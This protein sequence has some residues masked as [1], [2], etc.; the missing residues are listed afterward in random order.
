MTPAGTTKHLDVSYCGLDI[1]PAPIVLRLCHLE[2]LHCA[3]K[4]EPTLVQMQLPPLEICMG[5]IKSIR[6]FFFNADQQQLQ[7]IAE[8][9]RKLLDTSHVT[10]AP[11]IIAIIRASWSIE[12]APP[13]TQQLWVSVTSHMHS[14]SFVPLIDAFLDEHIDRVADV[15]NWSDYFGRS[16]LATTSPLCKRAML[17]RALFVGKYDITD[18]LRHEYKS[19]TCTVYLVDLVDDDKRIRVA[20][21]FMKNAHEFEREMRSRDKLLALAPGEE[22]A[23]RHHVIQVLDSYYH[24]NA[25]FQASM[26]KRSWLVD[27]DQPCLIV[28]PAADRNLRVIMDNERIT[29]TF[30]IKH[31]FRQIL[32]CV[33]CMHKRSII[34]GDL[35]PRNIVRTGDNLSLIDLDCS[36]EIGEMVAGSKHSSAY[37]PPESLELYMSIPS[38]DVALFSVSGADQCTVSFVLTLPMDVAPNAE[39][40]IVIPS[41][42]FSSVHSL[43][44]D[45]HAD[46]SCCTRVTGNTLAIASPV[47]LSVGKH[48]FTVVVASAGHSAADIIRPYF[49]QELRSLSVSLSN[50]QDTLSKCFA[51]ILRV[52]I[53]DISHD[54]WSL[55]VIL[56]RFFARESL[57]YEDDEDNIKDGSEHLL[58]LALWTDAFKQERLQRID[59][60]ATRALLSKLLEKEPWNRPRCIEDVIKM[61]FS[62]SDIIESKLKEHACIAHHDA[63]NSSN[64]VGDVKDLRTAKLS[65]AAFGLRH[66]LKVADNWNEE[67]ACT[68]RGIEDEI[69]RLKNC[70]D[71]AQVQASVLQQLGRLN[72]ASS[73]RKLA[74]ALSD[75]QIMQEQ[76]SARAVETIRF[77]IEN[78][79]GWCYGMKNVIAWPSD[80]V[81]VDCGGFLRSFC[82]PM[83]K[84]C[85][86]YCLDYTSV[87]ADLHYIMH[88]AAVEKQEWNGV[89]DLGRAGHVL[90]DFTSK[91]EAVAAK[92]TEAEV[93]ALRLYTSHS[94]NAINLPM[95]DL[96]AT[97]PHP[98]PSIV[99]C[100]QKGLKKLRVLRSDDA[101]SKQCVVLWRGMRSMKLSNEFSVD[102]G[103]EV[104]PMSTTTDIGVAL[105]Y[106]VKKDSRSALLFRFV[107]R[108]NLERGADVQWL[109]MF[110]GEAETLFPPL[111]FLQRTR[112]EPQVI[113]HDGFTV[114]VIEVSATLA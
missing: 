22:V 16:A 108:N 50:N 110:P 44:I 53:A 95:R 114:T 24:T 54:I 32:N 99:T 73:M 7:I 6:N 70:P 5:G 103:T 58:K 13:S 19:A 15:M 72:D 37:I 79:G 12:N 3:T 56:Y 30:L 93:V 48:M 87:A 68:L 107:T 78:A 63:S 45:S 111:T 23:S 97:H 85:Q 83:C 33:N 67:S 104:A 27:Y 18:G 106:A 112:P 10:Y 65:D 49:Q 51:R 4:G 46:L 42:K 14:D 88:E 84:R 1:L 2:S 86:K 52:V 75:L 81:R 96:D 35:K 62:E 113:E 94:F 43:V 101:S 71:C 39:F 34:H 74:S 109:S 25:A 11:V 59:D 98:L 55:G 69:D 41:L 57:F 40:S 77:E 17:N 89:R 26:K 100:I 36:A 28:M 80:V 8:T 21:K 91:P 105:Q 38:D 47:S 92:L 90:K 66:Y 102:G 60:I 61:P 31:M 9:V 76:G 20:L 29:Q 64:L 82:Q